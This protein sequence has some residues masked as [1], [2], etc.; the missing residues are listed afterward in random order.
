MTSPSCAPERLRA[1]DNSKRKTIAYARV[2]SPD[3]K[4]DWEG[5]KQVLELYCARQ[6]WTFAVV[7]DLGSGMNYH[8]K[9]VNQPVR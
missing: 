9:E 6:G 7:A 2:S 4:P 3:Q 1:P 8:K 5:Q